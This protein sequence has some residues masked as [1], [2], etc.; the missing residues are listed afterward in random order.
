MLARQTVRLSGPAATAFPC[1]IEIEILKYLF[2][3]AIEIEKNTLFCIHGYRY[4]TERY[5]CLT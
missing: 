4:G 2:S 1:V 5:R 3:C